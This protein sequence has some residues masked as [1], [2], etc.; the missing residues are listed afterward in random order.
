M[1]ELLANPENKGLWNTLLSLYRPG[2]K[3]LDENR[4]DRFAVVPHP[5]DEK[6]WYVMLEFGLGPRGSS[7]NVLRNRNT[8]VIYLGSVSR[9]KP[10]RSN[11]SCAGGVYKTAWLVCSQQQFADMFV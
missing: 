4:P 3:A 1:T 5:T 2:A 11:M 9:T 8:N 6:I 10:S 7:V